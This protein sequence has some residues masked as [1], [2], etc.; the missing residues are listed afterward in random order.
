MKKDTSKQ[1]VC[2]AVDSGN[3][4]LPAIRKLITVYARTTGSNVRIYDGSSRLLPEVFEECNI[5]ENFCRHCPLNAS[6]NENKSCGEMHVRAIEEA[7]RFDG[8]YI[9]TCKMGLVFWTVPLFKEGFYNGSLRGS[10]YLGHDVQPDSASLSE[11]FFKRLMKAKRA[12]ADKVKSMAE[13]LLLCAASLSSGSGDYHAMLRRRAE[14]Q[15]GINFRLASLKAKYKLG[16]PN[17]YQIRHEQ[18]LFAFLSRGELES[19]TFCL[20]DLLAAMLFSNQDNFNYLRLRAL[21]L[22]ILMLRAE[23]DSGYADD[24]VSQ[25]RCPFIR[26]IKKAKTF[27]D[28]ADVL[29]SLVRQVAGSIAPFRGIPHAAAMRRVERFI[30]KNFT[31]KISLSEIASVA[32]LSAPYFS[33]IFREEMGENFSTYLNR[34]RIEKAKYMLLKTGLSLSDIACACCFADQG[35]FSRQFKSFTGIS[36]GN[37]RTRGGAN[38]REIFVKGIYPE[39]A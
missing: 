23:K 27:E 11:E 9:Y 38:I 12:D 10:G 21:E 16:I 14:Q 1:A 3:A 19:A 7:G 26:Q 36:P 6:M 24:M 34:L 39:S 17:G 29:H 28:L 25:A 22:A 4:D 20:D 33:T 13:M 30:Q 35:W 18:Q 32:G 31:R 37:Y 5:E 2:G 15:R 8:V